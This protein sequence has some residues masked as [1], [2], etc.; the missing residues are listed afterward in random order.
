MKAPTPD[1]KKPEKDEDLAFMPAHQLARLLDSKQVSSVE[2]TKFFLDRLR[3]YDSA[4]KCVVSFTDDLAMKQAK[5]ADEE[6]RRADDEKQRADEA[7]RKTSEAE[8][9]TGE[10][11]RRAS[12]LAQR[13]SRMTELTSKLLSGSATPDYMAELAR[14]TTPERE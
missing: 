7:E 9:K 8:R 2:L 3:K 1:V 13:M 12:A 4:L 6:K 10:A 11:E 14:L 5:R